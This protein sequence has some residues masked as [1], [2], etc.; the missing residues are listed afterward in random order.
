MV[1]LP[2]SIA[3]CG[4]APLQAPLGER[5]NPVVDFNPW[6]Y[7][8]ARSS[9]SSAAQREPSRTAPAAGLLAPYVLDGSGLSWLWLSSF[10]KSKIKTPKAGANANGNMRLSVLML[11]IS[12]NV[13]VPQCAELV[14]LLLISASCPL[15][16]LV[17]V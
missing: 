6:S 2:G 7:E 9:C 16:E 1:G 14:R 3:A 5:E 12:S 4:K 13:C 10:L 17:N 11:Y 15:C 8:R